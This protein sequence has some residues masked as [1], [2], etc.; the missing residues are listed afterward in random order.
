MQSVLPL[1]NKVEQEFSPIDAD[2]LARCATDMPAGVAYF[3]LAALEGVLPQWCLEGVNCDE[4]VVVPG[5][6]AIAVHASRSGIGA[7]EMVWST[8]ATRTASP[9]QAA[10]HHD[11]LP[12]LGKFNVEQRAVVIVSRFGLRCNASASAVWVTSTQSQPMYL[13][14]LWRETLHGPAFTLLQQRASGRVKIAAPH[15]PVVI[16][17]AHIWEW[18]NGRRLLVPCL[19][20][21]KRNQFSVS[22]ASN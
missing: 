7:R 4:R 22:I 14:G 19:S 5:D 15:M 20:W 2:V 10:W 11:I 16:D 13:A 6:A 17:D 9:W 3:H 18:L 8:A 21:R 12:R 1:F